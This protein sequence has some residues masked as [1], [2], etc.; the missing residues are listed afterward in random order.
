[1]KKIAALFLLAAMGYMMVGCNTVHG[2]GKDVEKV[3]DKVQEKS[4]R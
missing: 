2:F 1:M 4:A 3:G